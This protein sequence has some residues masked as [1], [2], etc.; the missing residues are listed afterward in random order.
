MSCADKP[1]QSL[2][3]PDVLIS[4]RDDVVSFPIEKGAVPSVS[5][6]S[7]E[8]LGR[9]FPLQSGNLDA[10]TGNFEY[11]ITKAGGLY[12]GEYVYKSQTSFEYRG[13]HDPRRIYGYQSPDVP[14][15][16]VSNLSICY[17]DEYRHIVIGK[18]DTATST[19]DRFMR[20]KAEF[21]SVYGPWVVAPPMILKNPVASGEHNLAMSTL[22]DGRLMAVVRT[23][24]ASG[25]ID[26]DVYHSTDGGFSFTLVSEKIIRN[27]TTD[28]VYGTHVLTSQIRMAV[29]GEYITL[30]FQT[31]GLNTWLSR[32]RGITWQRVTVSPVAG[33]FIIGSIPDP[34]DS[35]PFDIEA[36]DDS[37]TFLLCY[38]N[39]GSPNETINRVRRADGPWGLVVTPST[40]AHPS[41][42]RSV[43]LV[44]TP[45]Y[46]WQITF[47]CDAGTGTSSGWNFRRANLQNWENWAS[48]FPAFPGWE[49]V[50]YPHSLYNVER[51]PTKLKGVWTGDSISF[52]GGLKDAVTGAGI[53]IDFYFVQGGWDTRSVGRVGPAIRLDQAPVSTL[54][55]ATWNTFIGDLGRPL[56]YWDQLT[57]AGG[58]LILGGDRIR[59][60]SPGGLTDQA[61]AFTKLGGAS[62]FTFPDDWGTGGDTGMMFGFTVK[63]DP[64]SG[65]VLPAGLSPSDC[66]IGVR[67]ASYTSLAGGGEYLT[68]IRLNDTSL[69]HV[70]HG[71]TPSDTMV[72][73]INLVDWVEVRVSIQE[74][75]TTGVLEEQVAVYQHANGFW[76]VG[77][78]IVRSL[79]PAGAGQTQALFGIIE[80]VTTG[81]PQGVEFRDFWVIQSIPKTMKIINPVS[82]EGLLGQPLSPARYETERGMMVSWGGAGAALSDTYVGEVTYT[83]AIERAFNSCPRIQFRSEML[84][85]SNPLIL[86]GSRFNNAEWDLTASSG[87]L[88][89]T[90]MSATGP[91]GVPNNADVLSYTNLAPTPVAK[92][93]ENIFAYPNAF[94]GYTV[95]FWAQAS[96][97]TELAISVGGGAQL[98]FILDAGWRRYEFSVESGPTSGVQI[99]ILNYPGGGVPYDFSIFEIR[100][101]PQITFIMDSHKSQVNDNRYSHN[102]ASVFGTNCRQWIIDYSDVQDFSTVSS[103]EVL[104]TALFKTDL[105]PMVVSACTENQL[106]FQVNPEVIRGS[107]LNKYIRFVTGSATDASLF[108]TWKVIEHGDDN[109]ILVESGYA[110]SSI[111]LEFQGVSAGDEFIVFDDHGAVMFSDLK[112]F[113][114]V[115]VRALDV[116][117]AEHELRLGALQ[118]GQRLHI[119]VPMDWS[120]TDNQQPNVTTYRSRGAVTWAYNEGPPQRTISGRIVGDVESYRDK[121]RFVQNYLQ[122][123]TR[124]LTLVLD[125]DAIAS[126]G[127]GPNNKVVL[128]R[129]NSGNQQDNSA[130]Y[131]DNDGNLRTAGDLSLTFTEEV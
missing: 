116:D 53:P 74:N 13:A 17:S 112:K 35:F 107:L 26:F 49:D 1:S 106:Q 122:Y 78:A 12:S 29:S 96:Q 66:G 82:P 69:Q 98:P 72:F 95:Q 24:D 70:C 125:E 102:A 100:A 9:A 56:S 37:G 97:P 103:S 43:M 126:G 4:G 131:I 2:I 8:N 87:V 113:R 63:V 94:G 50:Q 123:E 89:N 71:P 85:L 119:D 91:F 73:N 127:H 64:G 61:H 59:F 92:I 22:S 14:T 54:N 34:E 105:L 124:A 5:V 76:Q 40:F 86:S 21:Q 11:L 20:I 65:N 84:R 41:T 46:I 80:P 115:R 62:P 48:V 101:T 6:P 27:F 44:K 104:D 77:S 28:G 51:Y 33:D 31:G 18:I 30:C 93:M 117:F 118:I 110:P 32:D 79:N 83:Y 75:Q 15:A 68:E 36:V 109:T 99:F 38:L 25:F 81:A 90:P 67:I 88:T 130:W 55:V 42:V 45:D 47:F 128:C 39:P 3:I 121:L 7:I 120:F 108:S 57:A 58:S 60:E 16:G 111:N 23:E 10:T 129:I 19:F 114:Y 52:Y